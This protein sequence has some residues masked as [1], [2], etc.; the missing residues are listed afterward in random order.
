[1]SDTTISPENTE[2]APNERRAL[3]RKLA[4]GGAGAAAGA[5]LLN[6]GTASAA[7]EPGA[8]DLGEAATN[9]SV[10]PTTLVHDP[11]AAR[12]EGPSS[13]SVAG[14]VPGATAPFPAQVGGY[15]NA[16]VANGIHGSTDGCRPA[17]VS[18]PP[19]CRGGRSGTTDPVP[20]AQAVASSNGA[21]MFVP[22]RSV[23]RAD[24]GQARRRRA[25]RRQG[26]N[27]LVHGSRTDDG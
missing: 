19:T 14:A 3:L 12:T 18:S 7:A 8:L 23:D 2:E 6:H 20:T 1:M 16:E 26:R 13:L 24:T 27:A 5:V 10:T 4:I 11:A 9:T 15:G 17:S 21:H 25:V 22:R